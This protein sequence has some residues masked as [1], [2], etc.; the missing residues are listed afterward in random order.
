MGLTPARGRV[1]YRF[2]DDD[3]R[4]QRGY[5]PFR[6]EVRAHSGSMFPAS[7]SKRLEQ[8]EERRCLESLPNNRKRSLDHRWSLEIIPLCTGSVSIPFLGTVAAG[9]PIEAVEIPESI[10]VP[11]NLLGNGDNFALRVRGDSMVDEGIRDGDILIVTRQPHAENGQT[12]VVL[13]EGEATVKKFYRHGEEVELRPANS[14]ME[15]IRVCADKVEIVG[16][17]IGLLRHYRHRTIRRA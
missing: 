14:R 17:V 7:V 15:P 12:V 1:C 9:T 2:V 11:E 16:T 8:F 13:V 6:E 10:E 4:K 3:H 5:S